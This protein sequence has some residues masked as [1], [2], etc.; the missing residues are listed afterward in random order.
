MKM[1]YDLRDFYRGFIKTKN[2]KSTMKFKNTDVLTFDEVKDLP[3][4][5]GVLNDNAVL[6][7]VSISDLV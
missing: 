1:S 3:E 6:I 7:E 4:Y 2:K 5:A